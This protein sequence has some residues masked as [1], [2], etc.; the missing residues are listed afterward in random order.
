MSRLAVAAA[1]LVLAAP[2]VAAHRVLADAK[3]TPGVRNSHV[4]QRTIDS[5]ICV[6]GW[7]KTVRPPVSYTNALK[8]KQMAVYHEHGSPSLYEEDHLISLELGGS[9]RDP[10]N[11]W[12]EPIARA[13][14]VDKIENQLHDDVCDGALTL[15]AAQREIARV[16]HEDG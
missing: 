7:T 13:R 15:R 2:A 14:V 6:K 11:L 4:T 3:L 8:L 16:K 12:P 1:F 10:R 5:T 9:P